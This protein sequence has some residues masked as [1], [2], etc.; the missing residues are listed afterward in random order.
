MD[1]PQSFKTSRKSP[2]HS[3]TGAKPPVSFAAGTDHGNRRQALANRRASLRLDVASFAAENYRP[4]VYLKSTMEADTDEAVQG[5]L[6]SLTAAC[7]KSV[8]ELQRAVWKNHGEFLEVGKGIMEFEG[9]LNEL[10]GIQSALRSAANALVSSAGVADFVS[11]GMA[12]WMV[13]NVCRR[14]TG[15]GRGGRTRGNYRAATTAGC[16]FQ[17]N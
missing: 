5:A 1:S 14:D 4:E 6:R 16:T 2:A 15:T 10:R 7:E 12:E 9:G 3:P 13:G 8:S 11:F 17:N